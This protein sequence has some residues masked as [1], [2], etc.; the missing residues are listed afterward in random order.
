[1]YLEL[2]GGAHAGSSPAAVKAALIAAGDPAPCANNPDGTCPP[3]DPDGVQE[4]LLKF[5]VLLEVLL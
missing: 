1:M 4:P 2:A 3:K 5:P